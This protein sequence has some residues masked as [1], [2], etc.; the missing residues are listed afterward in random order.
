M[1]QEDNLHFLGRADGQVKLRGLRIELSEIESV[2]LEAEGV[3]AAACTVR[4]NAKGIPQLAGYVVPR[5]G[6]AV[7]EQRLDEHLRSRLPAWMVP[8]VVETVNTLP[9][10]ASGKLDRA[11]LPEPRQRPPRQPEG[12]ER[13]LSETERQL[14]ELW[15]GLFSPLRVSLNDDFFLHL[16]GHSLLAAQMVSEL[17]RA[18]RF[19]GLTVLDVYKY[20]TIARLASAVDSAA[21]RPPAQ[22]ADGPASNSHE[23]RQR[24]RHFIAGAVQS[25]SLYFVFG[26]QGLQSVTPYLVFFL[27][28]VH[29]SAWEAAVWA[30]ASGVAV[31]PIL[32]LLAVSAK[33]ILLGRIRPGTCP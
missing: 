5:E 14:M 13:P 30:A 25:F 22:T 11:S 8:A 16:G 32:V 6:G 7:N 27:L 3:L 2:L 9:R 31:L 4:H 19:A 18:T 33:W 26:F 12:P 29:H 28:A 10:L 1:D 17:R 20:P 24:V 21:P 15:S 23:R